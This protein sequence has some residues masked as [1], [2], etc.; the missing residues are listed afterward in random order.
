MVLGAPPAPVSA[1]APVSAPAVAVGA[2]AHSAQPP[3][4]RGQPGR[5]QGRSASG[6]AGWCVPRCGRAGAPPSITVAVPAVVPMPLAPVAPIAPASAPASAS[7]PLVVPSSSAEVGHGEGLRGE[8]RGAAEA[9]AT[10]N[11]GGA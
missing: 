4:Q 1:S 8:G 3:S 5:P 2:G 10:C 11:S 6:P 9:P 7:S